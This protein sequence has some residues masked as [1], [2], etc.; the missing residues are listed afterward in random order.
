MIARDL[1]EKCDFISFPAAA[2]AAAA[3]A[4]VSY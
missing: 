3:A 1:T 4:A 2:A